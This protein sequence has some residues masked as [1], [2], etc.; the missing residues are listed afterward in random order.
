[1]PR[2]PGLAAKW[3]SL[4]IIATIAVLGA[5][6]SLAIQSHAS[7]PHDPAWLVV[8]ETDG[9]LLR[10]EIA[11]SVDAA[12]RLLVLP[13]NTRSATVEAIEANGAS[14]PLASVHV[15]PIMIMRGTPVAPIWFDEEISQ[16]LGSEPVAITLRAEDTDGNRLVRAQSSGSGPS[17]PRESVAV[18]RGGYLIIAADQFAA[19]VQPLTDWKTACGYDVSMH[20]TS[21]TGTTLNSIR[22]FVRQAYETWDNPPLYLLLVGDVEHIPSGDLLGNASDHFYACVDGDD[23]LADIYVGRICAKTTAD[24]AVQVAKIVGY[25][26]RPDMTGIA[27]EDTTTWFDRGLMVAGNHGSSTPIPTSQWLAAELRD[28]GFS[29]VDSV[30]Y[31]PY[32]DGCSQ[33]WGC[34]INDIIN[35]GVTVVNY[36]GWAREEPPGWDVPDYTTDDIIQ[37]QNGWKLPFVFSFVCNTGAF[38]RP[39][40]DCFGEVWVKVGTPEIPLGAVGFIGTAEHE[41]KTRWNDRLDMGTFEALCYQGVNQV[42]PMLAAGKECLLAYFPTEVYLEDV[43]TEE[44]VEF[45]NYVYNVLGDPSLALWTACPT[46]V[47]VP[48]LPRSIGYGANRMELRV[49][50]DDGATPVSGAHVSLTQGGSLIGYGTTDDFGDVALNFTLA[51]L[52]PVTCTVTG[53]NI[54]PLQSTID[55]NEESLALT[56]R[57]ANLGGGVLV[58]GVE[59]EF[60]VLAENTGTGDIASA[61]ATLVVPEGVEVLSG[62]TSFGAIPAGEIASTT[63][64]LRIRVAPDRENGRLLHFQLIPTVS[65]QELRAS[66]FVLEVSAPELVCESMTDG[67]DGVF[68]PGESGSFVLRVRNDGIVATGPVSATLSV[69]APG[70]TLVKPT[71]SFPSIEAGATTDNSSD[72]FVIAIDPELA[73]GTVIPFVV[74]AAAAGPVCS[75]AGNLILGSVDAG[76]PLGPDGGGYYCYDSADIDYPQQVPAYRW[77]EISPLYG[78]PG[79]WLDIDIN[80][81]QPRA[82]GLPFTFKYYGQEYDSVLVSDNGWISFETGYFYDERNWAMPDR[83]GNGCM[84]AAY[85]DNLN[86]QFAGTDGIYGWYD[87]AA[88]HFVIEW[89]RLRS[90]TDT[91]NHWQTFEIVLLDPAYHY[92]ESGNGEIIFQYKHIIND[93]RALMY[94]TIGIE[95]QSET[96]GIQYSYANIYPPEA[97]PL[98]AGLA[99]KFTTDPPV[100]QPLILRSFQ[101]MLPP[102]PTDSGVRLQWALDDDRP[103]SGFELWKVVSD[104]VGPGEDGAGRGEQRAERVNAELIPASARSFIDESASPIESQRYELRVVGPTGLVRTLGEAT[105]N[106]FANGETALRL[107]GRSPSTGPTAILYQTGSNAAAELAVFDAT[108]RRVRT[109]VEPVQGQRAG[110]ITWDGRDASGRPLASGLYWVRLAAGSTNRTARLVIIR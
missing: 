37:L 74:T 64:P 35:N 23:F 86:P 72:P 92:A 94:S 39:D 38:A 17:Q 59:A 76:A 52:T 83:W 65:E 26:S 25:E 12:G 48:A 16:T 70:V 8:P 5:T 69:L 66:E 79:T 36:R 3:C 22:D 99:I 110:L 78:G 109:L 61:T 20:L 14:L 6:P 46:A 43:T 11:P 81:R 73:I 13:A 95:D 9:T 45:Y 80:D 108:G 85:W 10:M 44:A 56:C 33:T 68:W 63:T 82:V 62:A 105:Y 42:G 21:E 51:G 4:A 27:P 30:Y 101:A 54:N 71:A 102:D 100:Y 67:G 41:S 97:S 93:D 104:P 91:A 55:V 88:H 28:F 103:L 32:S 47:R 7:V 2:N 18:N 49:V 31:P 96:I 90:V 58:P 53:T 89:N 24:V 50:R 19:E 98:A 106:P 84:V 107:V 40:M 87:E 60:H 15:G 77:I 34:P 57:E 29:M 1:M 75:V